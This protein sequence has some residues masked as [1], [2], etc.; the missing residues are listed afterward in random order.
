MILADKIINLRK[1]NGWSQEELAEKLGV[2]R[3]SISKYEGAQSI[4]DLN[5][6]IKLSQIFG[7]TTD[8]LM[9]DEL[10]VDDGTPMLQAEVEEGEKERV[11]MEMAQEYLQLN[12]LSAKR[13]AV[14]TMLCI[15]SPICLLLLVGMAED[16]AFNVSENA[17]IGIGLCTLILLVAIAVSIFITNSMKMQKYEFLESEAFETEYGVSG[18]VKEQREKAKDAYVRN[19]VLG[20][21]LTLC[22]LIPLFI[23]IAITEREFIIIAMVCILLFIV[24]IGVTFF[25]RGLVPMDGMNK[26]L[27]EGDYTPKKK[28]VG[29]KISPF[30]GAY[31]LLATAVYLGYSFITNNWEMSWVVWPIAGVLYPVYH[32]IVSG[33]VGRTK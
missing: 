2:S 25:I 13:I 20:A 16:P 28:R 10:T 15:F 6:I 19:N 32:I 1:K 24:G 4:P 21:V 14:A 29:K 8:C 23:G 3:Q 11:T 5:K 26:L 30:T 17:A 12:R 9:K 22:S 33:L 27:E 18:M 31:W 7:V